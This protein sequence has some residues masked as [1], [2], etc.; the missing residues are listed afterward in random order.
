MIKSN[1]R[2]GCW[3]L[4]I[5]I[6]IILSFPI[7]IH[8]TTTFNDIKDHWSEPYINKAINKG[9]IKG[10][11]DNSFK[12]DKQVSRAEFISMINRAFGNSSTSKIS[13][14]D[15]HSNEWY[16]MDISKAV[17]AAYVA[18]YKNGSFKPNNPINRQEACFMISRII[19][20][21]GS[22]GQLKT[23]LDSNLISKWAYLAMSKI[24]GK[25]Y[26]QGYK[27]GKI[28]PLD[29]LTRAQAAKII[30]DIIDHEKIV[31]TNQFVQKDG[32]VLTGTIYS[33]NVTVSKDLYNG[34]AIIDNCVVLGSLYIQGGG[35]DTITIN[36]SRIARAIAD[37][38][39]SSI[40]LVAKGET[41]IVDTIC[42]KDF[43][44]QTSNLSGG[45]FG[46]G[47][48]KIII[49]TS[50]NAI[51]RGNFPYVSIEGS[52]AN[53]NLESGIISELY[54]SSN[55]KKSNI[56]IGNGTTIKNAKVY[57]ESYFHGNG[58]ISNIEIYA[59]NIIFNNKQYAIL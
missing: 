56:T 44:L 2:K 19:P 3:F 53:L 43:I 50:A 12:P 47:F 33:N 4:V 6:V 11:P 51:L 42:S 54:V 24:N 57:T 26:I 13:F 41:S 17:R 37:K 52:N 23:Y 18:G 8:A 40:K 20:T 29:N 46:H 14:S 55:A 32:T 10:Y 16:Y 30:S 49:S 1:Y 36:N 25:G 15:V 58:T 27:D 38:L 5:T 45:D 48:Q 39:E 7:K 31:S 28:H 9:F 35:T 22:Y 59:K 21:S 34:S